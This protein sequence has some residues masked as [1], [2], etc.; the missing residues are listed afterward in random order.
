MYLFI[1]LLY[2]S[3]AHTSLEQMLYT[4]IILQVYHIMY[5][6]KL[7]YTWCTEF[8][9]LQIVYVK[10]VEIIILDYIPFQKDSIL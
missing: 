1:L 2:P 6:V 7:I 10:T 9:M 3:P 4:S 5:V 8:L